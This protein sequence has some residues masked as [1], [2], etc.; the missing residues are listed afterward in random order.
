VSICATRFQ[1]V[2]LKL[3]FVFAPGFSLLPPK[4]WFFS[5]FFFSRS[6]LCLGFHFPGPISA[7]FFISMQ[8]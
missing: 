5:V 8:E 6:F 3:V 2:F 1:L 4:L 7:R